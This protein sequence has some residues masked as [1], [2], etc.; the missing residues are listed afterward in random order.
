V[1]PGRVGL[2]LAVAM[3]FAGSASAEPVLLK[4]AGSLKPAFT[5]LIAAFEA[6]S[7]AKV[8]PEFGA[9]GLMKDKILSGDPTD[10]FTS[11]NLEHPKAVA[12]A[13]GGDAKPFTH[14]TL[15]ALAQ[16][17]LAVTSDSLLDTLLDPRIRVA[18]STPKSDPAGDYAFALFDKADAL[19]AGST[20]TLKAKALQLTGG[21]NSVKPP[22]GRSSYGFIMGEKQADIFLTYCTNAV[23]AA[24][25]VP[26]LQTIAIPAS[27]EV[28][29]D[30][31]MIVLSTNPDAQKLAD[32]IL[33]PAGQ[34]VLKDF[35]FSAPSK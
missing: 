6:Q 21:P 32:F 11:A 28:G 33:S 5:R 16:P 26:T 31:G 29:A 24:K 7:G 13:K 12:A 35:G 22:E 34:S 23:V 3:T 27:L 15:C 17:E 14:N 9:S 20:A 30:Y 18:T 8:D 19:K 25:E 1:S 4:S 10:I 2:L